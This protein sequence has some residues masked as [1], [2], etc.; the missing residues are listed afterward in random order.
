MSS[1]NP[2]C[3]S[4]SHLSVNFAVKYV[5]ISAS[6]QK[7][8][9]RPKGLTAAEVRERTPTD[10]SLVCPIDNKLFRD[11]VKTPCCDTDYCEE[12]I[13]T[14][15]LER[16]FL[17][18]SCGKRI[19]SLDKLV[20]DKPMRTKVADYIDKVIEES[21]KSEDQEKSNTPLANEKVSSRQIFDSDLLS[22]ESIIA[23]LR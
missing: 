7:Q 17:C 19:P 20:V 12:C 4:L 11:A 14:H 6:W 1:L 2:I 15:L 10:M 9:L 8:V 21:K 23:R 22:D 13:Q 18:P 16:D 3:A 5:Y